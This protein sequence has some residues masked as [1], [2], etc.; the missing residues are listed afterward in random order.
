MWKTFVEPVFFFI[1]IQEQNM[2][3][4]VVMTKSHYS[5]PIFISP[6]VSLFHKKAVL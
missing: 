2:F 4:L 5:E 6:Q 3:K 1:A